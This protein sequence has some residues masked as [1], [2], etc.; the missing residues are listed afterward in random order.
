RAIEL[1]EAARL[2]RAALT[3]RDDDQR[4][5]CFDQSLTIYARLGRPQQVIQVGADYREFLLFQARR[6]AGRDD[7]ARRVRALDLQLGESYLVRG[8]YATAEA[9]L[10]QAL[11]TPGPAPLHPVRK[12]TGL[13]SLAHSAERRGDRA[14][15]NVAWQKVER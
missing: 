15:A 3:A 11:D 7:T 2:F 6:A 5:R 12:I 9:H 8:H 13:T 1:Q 10:K 4:L 14:Q